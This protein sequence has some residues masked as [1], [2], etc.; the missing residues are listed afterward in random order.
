MTYPMTRLEM[1]KFP[2]ATDAFENLMK[3]LS[4]IFFPM[5]LEAWIFNNNMVIKASLEAHIRPCG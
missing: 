1:L 5:D 3:V 2:E 4:P